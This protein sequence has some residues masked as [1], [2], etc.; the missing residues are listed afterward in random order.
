MFNAT[1]GLNHL[2]IGVENVGDG[3]EYPMTQAQVDANIEL[4]RYLK[5]AWPGITHLIGH[6]EY[7]SFEYARHEYFQEHDTKR[8][9]RKIDPGD[10]FMQA[11]RAGL[12]G[13]PLLGPPVPL[14]R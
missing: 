1:I 13:V 4:V 5:A 8:R 11:V 9:T 12:S 10:D 14:S 2:S 3:K 7:R 6:H